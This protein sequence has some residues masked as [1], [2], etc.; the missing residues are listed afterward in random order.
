MNRL[1]LP[2]V[3]AICQQESPEKISHS[4]LVTGA[5]T[6]IVG[7]DD[8]IGWT[9]PKSTRDGW[10]LPNGRIL[11]ALARTKECPKGAVVEVDREGK[12]T[13]EYP[14]TQSEVNTVQPLPNGNLVLTEAGANPRLLEIDRSGKIVVEL[15]IR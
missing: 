11:L 2:M 5:Q 10:V 12:V 6:Y 15:P 4:F 8:Q 7:N 3:L 9:Y 13:F 14:G 1:F